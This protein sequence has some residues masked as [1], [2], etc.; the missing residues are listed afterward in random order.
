MLVDGGACVN[1]IPGQVFEKL[2]HKDEELLKTNMTLS[3]FSSK[4]SDARGDYLQGAHGGK[5]NST[6]IVLRGGCDGEVY[7]LLE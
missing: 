6:D 4:A 1:I 2:G 7:I 3:G 5:Q